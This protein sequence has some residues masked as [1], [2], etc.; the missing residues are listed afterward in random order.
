MAQTVN[1]LTA[2]KVDN[3]RTPGMYPDGAGLYLQVT[4]TAAKSWIL[5]YSLRGVAREMG[6]GPLSKVS[7]AEARRKR[8]DCHKLLEDHID[9][10][11]D[12]ERRRSAAVLASVKTI[13]FREAADAY[14]ASH[15]AG[16]KNLK[17]AAQWRTTLATYA[18]PV[19]GKLLV[20]EIDTGLVHRVLEKIWTS[21][22]ETASRVRG[23][24]ESVLDWAKVNKYRDGENPARWRGNLDKLLPKRSKVR[25]VKHHP[26]LSYDKLPAFMQELRKQDGSAARAL[27]FCILT[28]ARTGETLKA[29]PNEISH[30]E[31]LWTVPAARMKGGLEHRVPLC[32]RAL[33]I[34]DNG[35]KD[36]LFPSQYHD[37]KHLSDMAMLQ[38]LDRMGH[39]DITVHG[40]RSSFKDWA[41]DRTGFENYVVESAL[42]HAVGDKVE[43]AYA[44]SDVIDKR[45]K[46]MEAWAAYCASTP[47]PTSGKVVSMRSA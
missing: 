27:E 33:E 7:L 6:L 25:G 19:M 29:R 2:T 41:R 14:C 12:R 17:H 38:L 28:A 18:E 21:K 22:P 35:S 16:L 31:K 11:K 15:R 1:R 23:R 9:P 34:I 47:A 30:K 44:R 26:A 40:F 13:T 45:R 4:S 39:G 46:L 10:I 42:A 36:Y 32:H 20:R 3:V 37:D 8:A 24:I 43:A 5:R